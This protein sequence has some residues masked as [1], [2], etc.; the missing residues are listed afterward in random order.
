MVLS[1]WQVGPYMIWYMMLVVSLC[2]LRY[3][4]MENI[5]FSI[6][7]DVQVFRYHLW[8]QLDTYPMEDTGRSLG[9]YLAY[10][11]CPH[12]WCIYG[13]AGKKLK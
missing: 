1:S 8:I 12:K 10:V 7:Q 2:Q 9:R 5:L 3:F 11:T 6:F 13:D 4:Q